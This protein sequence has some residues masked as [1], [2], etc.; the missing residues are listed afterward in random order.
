MRNF[1]FVFC[2]LSCLCFAAAAVVG[3]FVR[4]LVTV[5]CLLLGGVIFAAA[6]FLARAR[7]NAKE[8]EARRRQRP[9]FMDPPAQG[10]DEPRPEQK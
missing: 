8:E 6:M 5:I 7:A 2:V 3:A 9:D 1:Q 4:D 10:D